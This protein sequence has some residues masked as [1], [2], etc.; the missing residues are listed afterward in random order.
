MVQQPNAVTHSIILAGLN[1]DQDQ[2]VISRPTLNWQWDGTLN[3][4]AAIY[5]TDFETFV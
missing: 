5:R 1:V 3:L 4:L 2:C